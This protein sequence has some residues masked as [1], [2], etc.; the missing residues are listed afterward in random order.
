MSL[1]TFPFMIIVYALIII[2][3]IVKQKKLK[4]KNN[5][6]EKINNTVPYRQNR[7]RGTVSDDGHRVPRAQ[8]LTC[9]TQYGHRHNS[10]DDR[11]YAPRYIV[12][13]E[14]EP[15]YVILNGV[16]RKIKDIKDF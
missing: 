5:K 1:S 3:V 9:E 14:P 16:K 4:G 7:Q 6:Q 12:H 10:P 11:N 13:E 15:G 2:A 8:D